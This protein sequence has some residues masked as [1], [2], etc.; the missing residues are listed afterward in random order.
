MELMQGYVK[1][2]GAVGIEDLKRWPSDSHAVDFL[3]KTMSTNE[4]SELLNV[5]QTL[6]SLKP[7]LTYS[8]TP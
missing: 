5:R 8:S 1:E 7:L 6:A 4:I 3:S 2:G